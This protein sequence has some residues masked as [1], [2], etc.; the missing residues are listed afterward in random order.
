MSCC[1]SVWAPGKFGFPL[2][3]RFCCSRRVGSPGREIFLGCGQQP[4]WEQQLRAA[5]GRCLPYFPR[6]TDIWSPVAW[7]PIWNV[8]P[9][10][11]VLVHR[12]GTGQQVE[13]GALWDASF[14]GVSG[15]WVF[16][17]PL[18][19]LLF[20]FLPKHPWELLSLYCSTCYLLILAHVMANPK[21]L[22]FAKGRAW[23]ILL[24]V[25]K[26]PVSKRDET[27]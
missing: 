3:T 18:S 9:V 23:Y 17:L 4:E 22:M 14:L 1:G 19:V 11:L 25:W 8:H 24:D 7:D 20:A 5:P 10:P 16:F 2:N 27:F 13:Q 21:L 26:D 15:G 12:S 6:P